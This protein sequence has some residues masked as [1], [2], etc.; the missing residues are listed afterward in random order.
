[1]LI[2]Y[3]YEITQIDHLYR[4]NVSNKPIHISGCMLYDMCVG[5][6]GWEE[7]TR[8]EYQSLKENLTNKEIN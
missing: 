1:M 6:E 7:I 5:V 3:I 4:V 2:S 8:V